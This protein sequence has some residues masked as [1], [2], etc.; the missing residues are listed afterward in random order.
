MLLETINARST[1][2]DYVSAFVMSIA[3]GELISES[4]KSDFYSPS[5]ATCPDLRPVVAAPKLEL[6]HGMNCSD[7]LTPTWVF[8]LNSIVNTEN[9]PLTTESERLR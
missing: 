7:Y 4:L 8:L 9:H 3:I 6:G 2:S 5:V 1:E